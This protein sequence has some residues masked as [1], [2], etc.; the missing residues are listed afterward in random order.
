MLQQT[1]DIPAMDAGGND[2]I[3]DLE[4]VMLQREK[5][6]GLGALIITP[7]RELAL[8]VK[9]HISSVCKYT[10]VKVQCDDTTTISMYVLE[11]T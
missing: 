7:T 10:K 8:Q 4:D 3:V 2:E 9:N 1:G 5:G 6:E 11:D